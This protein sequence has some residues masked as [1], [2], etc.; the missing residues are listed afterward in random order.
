MDYQ[1]HY[2]AL[3]KRAQSRAIDG[4]AERH[5][6]LPR[7]LGGSDDP[8]NIAALTPEEHYVAHQLLVKIH[9]HEAKMVFAALAMTRGRPSN[10]RYGWLRRLFAVRISEIHKGKPKPPM[11]D[12]H[13]RNIGLGQLG[14]IRGPHSD[15]HKARLSAAHTGKTLTDEHRAKLAAAKLGTKR[16]PYPSHTCPSCGT[17]GSGGSMKRWHFD[18]CKV[19]AY[20]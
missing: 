18:N 15:Q 5:H 11:T 16:A 9:P 14:R 1:R 4:Y 7:C 8:E 3:I 10:K 17:V 13:R 12:E 20:G 2:D 6:I 19:V